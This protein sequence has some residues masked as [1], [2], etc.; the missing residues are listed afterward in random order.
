MSHHRPSFGTSFSANLLPSPS[1]VASPSP[2][3]LA[4]HGQSTVISQSGI[5]KTLDPQLVINP[6]LSPTNSRTVTAS[7][8]TIPS[9]DVH[10]GS[11]TSMPLLDS[12]PPPM[13]PSYTLDHLYSTDADSEHKTHPPPP[14]HPSTPSPLTAG[15]H[16]GPDLTVSFT[17]RAPVT[18]DPHP[19]NPSTI[20]SV[21]SSSSPLDLIHPTHA[22]PSSSSSSTLEV[23]SSTS[24]SSIHRSNSLLHLRGTNKKLVLG[25]VGLPARGK[26]FGR[27]TRLRLHSGD[28]VNVEEVRGGEQL[29]GDDGQPR[30][31]TPGSLTCGCDAMYR[32]VPQ[33]RGGAAFEVNGDHILVLVNPCP[34]RKVLCEGEQRRRWRVQ[35]YGLTTDNR[36][37]LMTRSYHSEQAADAEVERRLQHWWPLEWEVSVVDFL[38][39]PPQLRA[40]TRMFTPPAVTFVNPA[41]P[42]LESVLSTVLGATPTAAQVEWAAW[43]LGLWLT[44]TGV[45][46][47]GW[48]YDRISG[49]SHHRRTWKYLL[50]Y[51]SLFGEAMTRA[52][53][54]VGGALVWVIQPSETGCTPSI[55]RQL[56][57]AYALLTNKHVPQAWLCDSIDVRRQILAGI[58]DGASRRLP[59][60]GGCSLV[61]EVATGERAVVLGCK[62]LAAS[63]GVK[64]GRVDAQTAIDPHTR[65]Q[66][67]QHRITF[68]ADIAESTRPCTLKPPQRWETTWAGRCHSFTIRALA[69]G[70]YFGFAVHG[71]VNR[72]FLLEDFTVTHNVR[73]R[74]HTRRVTTTRRAYQRT[75]NC[76]TPS[77]PLLSHLVVR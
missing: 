64:G 47:E 30:V 76:F 7:P 75:T 29:M 1:V 57:C 58:V 46:S 37:R 71:G 14:H 6:N 5:V 38:A 11:Y 60:A 45:S 31:V 67:V 4:E 8:I 10:P 27:G 18:A 43:F 15:S 39:H 54:S 42:K 73:G 70:E 49:S 69:R 23:P 40:L 62:L 55:A 63:L 74:Y 24:S 50:Q 3:P 77:L 34:P 12:F 53:R 22:H 28:V 17:P 20:A 36:M 9:V 26:C 59:N 61:C 25:M 44:D 66:R 13:M 19:S 41:L 65:L 16:P 56:L 33:W 52:Q 68:G 2:P 48:L 72:R 51:H 21:A 32:V 35:E